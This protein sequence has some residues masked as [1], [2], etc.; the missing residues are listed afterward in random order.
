[1]KPRDYKSQHALMWWGMG[2]WERLQEEPDVGTL[3]SRTEKNRDGGRNEVGLPGEGATRGRGRNV[4]SL[5]SRRRLQWYR[6]C[7]RASSRAGQSVLRGLA[8]VESRLSSAPDSGLFWGLRGKKDQPP[9]EHTSLSVTNVFLLSSP[10]PSMEEQ[11]IHRQ[12][13]MGKFTRTYRG[14]RGWG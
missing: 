3:G 14:G 11:T 13:T 4:T 8:L 12:Q 1:M 10:Y 9:Q 6:C 7:T 2:R 5:T